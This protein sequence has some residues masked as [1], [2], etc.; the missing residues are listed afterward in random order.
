MR[1][2]VVRGAAPVAAYLA[3]TAGDIDALAECA[4]QI[5][6][7]DATAEQLSREGLKTAA[8]YDVGRVAEQELEEILR[9]L[10]G[11]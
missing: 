10:P 1:S 4:V 6:T 11:H 2:F 9:R 8:R 7:D 3:A 5:L